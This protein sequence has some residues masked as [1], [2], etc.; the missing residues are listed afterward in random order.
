MT[1]TNERYTND[2]I[3]GKGDYGVPIG[4]PQDVMTHASRDFPP[5]TAKPLGLV[6]LGPSGNPGDE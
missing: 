5:V 2:E 3:I 4:K 6:A 1:W